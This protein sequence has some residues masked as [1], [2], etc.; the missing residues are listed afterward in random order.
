[1]SSVV[2]EIAL[3]LALMIANG[4]F[5]GSE[6]AILSA[7]KIR[8]DQLVKQGDK[9]ARLALKL[10]NSPNNFLSTVQIGIT[11]IGILSGTLA[12]ATLAQRL[13][14][15]FKTI[16]LL[17]PYSKPLS[18][19]VVVTAITYLSLVIGELVPKRIALNNPEKIACSVASPMRSLSILM[20]PVVHLL[21]VSTDGLLKLL[22]IQA[23][24]EPAVTEEEIKVLIEQGTEAG[25]FE[26]SEQEIVSRV[27]R[28][29]DRAIK[30][31]MTPRT[32]ISWLDIA[33]PWEE[34]QQE[35]L[36]NTYSR[37]PVAQGSLDNCLGVV[38]A[39]DIL[40][41]QLAQAPV[42]LNNLLRSP[43]Y[44]PEN[45]RAL[46]V[47][48]IFQESGTHIALITDEYGG[49]EG[50]VTL[51]DLVEAIVGELPSVEDDEEPQIIR[52]EDGSWLL[53]GLLAIEPLKELLEQ[54][55]LPQ[56]EEEHY[57]TLGG[58]IMAVLGRVPT[59]GN[60]FEAVGFRFEVMDMDGTRVDKVLVVPLP[61]KTPLS[62][63][64]DDD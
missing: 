8:L 11:L 15:V 34:N 2:T 21:S 31:L 39:R 57:H 19:L 26:E 22:N 3:I 27:F 60:F 32:A 54:E 12:G 23:S 50:L 16:P 36:D 5:S 33:A 1:M 59:S 46:K 17:L 10:A 53:D 37:F 51:N 47:L 44:I 28:L 7:R 13:E 58:F 38:R 9:R 30:T 24:D 48:E 61:S 4:I 20:A 25:M 29:G 41:L 62:P 40:S 52:R 6:L 42:D 56:E 49:I 18:I 45:S 43:L 55:T 63:V 14:D 64:E 35:I